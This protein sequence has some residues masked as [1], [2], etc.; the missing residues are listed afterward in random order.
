M[1]PLHPR[2]AIRKCPVTSVSASHRRLS[3]L[4]TAAW[5]DV[6]SSTRHDRTS[7]LPAAWST[8][9]RKPG[10]L[11]S[12]SRVT[13]D[14]ARGRKRDADLHVDCSPGSVATVNAQAQRYGQAIHPALAASLCRLGGPSA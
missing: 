3:T 12:A 8:S 6:P 5:S 11:A 9:R 1:A 7:A 14:M 4:R 2:Y 13:C 10:E